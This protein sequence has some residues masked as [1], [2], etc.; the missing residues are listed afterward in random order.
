MNLIKFVDL[1]C[2]FHAIVISCRWVVA[3]L[4]L[5]RFSV[6]CMRAVLQCDITF[7]IV[8]NF[9]FHAKTV[10]W[11]CAIWNG[12][13]APNGRWYSALGGG[14]LGGR[15]GWVIQGVTPT[16]EQAGSMEG[17]KSDTF[18]TNTRIER[19]ALKCTFPPNTR[20]KDGSSLNK[21]RLR[22]ARTYMHHFTRSTS[23]QMGGRS[24]PPATLHVK[25]RWIINSAD[26]LPEG[27]M[28][29]GKDRADP[30]PAAPTTWSATAK[31]WTAASDVLIADNPGD[32]GAP[33][34]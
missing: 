27:A 1:C 6:D 29:E 9:G 16:P 20:Q 7:I 15:L 11:L 32:G 31:A 26:T 5:T 3:R 24:S 30:T 8:G 18:L 33:V 17:F 13:D 19:E 12:F 4:G 25:S 10:C 23:S 14:G 22:V 2:K 34:G 21:V 28:G